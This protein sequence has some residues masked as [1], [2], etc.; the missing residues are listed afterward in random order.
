MSTQ[1]IC[2]KQELTEEWGYISTPNYP[3]YYNSSKNCE[4]KIKVKP[5]QQIKLY[6]IDMDLESNG[7][8]GCPDWFYAHDNYHSVTLCGKRSNEDL[9]KS[10]SNEQFIQFMSNAAINRKGFWLYYEGKFTL[11]T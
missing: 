5:G 2:D 11:F 9:P 3:N 1:R 8:K 7:S 4:V 6:I 10:M